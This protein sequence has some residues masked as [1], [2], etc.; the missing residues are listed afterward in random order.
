[1]R[2]TLHFQKM[3]EDRYPVEPMIASIPGPA[4]M[5][6]S[7]SNSWCEP[8]RYFEGGQSGRQERYL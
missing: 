2:Q 7:Q 6:V 8:I 4:G 3:I 1:M 5:P